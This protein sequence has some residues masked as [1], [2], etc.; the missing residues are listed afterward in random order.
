M[1]R[2][3][4][5]RHRIYSFNAIMSVLFLWVS[6][7]FDKAFM[8][9]ASSVQYPWLTGIF[10]LITMLGEWYIFAVIALFLAILLFINK[11]PV[12]AFAAGTGVAIIVTTLLKYII[13]RPRP[14]ETMHIPSLV[15]ATLSSFPSG[16]ATALFAILPVVNRNFP[17]MKVITWTVA[18]LVGVSRIYFNVHYLS[19]VVAGAMIGYSIG[20]IFMKIGE[21]NGWK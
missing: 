13:G 18:I 12:I 7:L 17:K 16:H 4:P 21:H 20:W 3:I 8:M 10:Y 1:V 14:F 19:D 5:N 15:N 2:M 6:F 11:K 9:I